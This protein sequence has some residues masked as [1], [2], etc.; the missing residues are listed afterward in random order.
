MQSTGTGTWAKDEMAVRRV[1]YEQIAAGYDRRFAGN[2]R[3]GTAL[4]LEGLA[5]SIGAERILEVGCG[6]GHWLAG[7]ASLSPDLYGLDL[8]AGM[9]EQAQKGWPPLRLVRGRAGALAFRDAS[10]DLVYCVNAIHHFDAPKAFITEARRLLRPGGKLAVVG[11]DPRGRGGRWY[12][13]RYFPGVYERDLER[14]PSWGTIVDWMVEEG[15]TE[16][17]CQQVERIREQK[18][19]RSVLDDPFLQKDACSQLALLSEQ[20]YAAGMQ[21][22]EQA[23]HK[24]ELAGETLSFASDVIMAMIVGQARSTTNLR[25]ALRAGPSTTSLRFALR[26]GTAWGSRLRRGR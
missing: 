13:Y 21:R 12:V 18:V 17:E 20:E 8:S 4:A 10:F 11:T 23:L 22:I 25:F 19:G 7:L 9:L 14:F 3:E 2:R 1:D 24:A 15:F 6:T 5:R 16:I 26:A